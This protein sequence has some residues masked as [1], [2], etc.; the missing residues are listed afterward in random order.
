[1]EIVNQDQLLSGQREALIHVKRHRRFQP[2]REASF[3]K[4]GGYV[5]LPGC[6][7]RHKLAIDQVLERC[8]SGLVHLLVRELHV[9]ERFGQEKLDLILK[10]VDGFK[11]MEGGKRNCGGKGFFTEVCTMP[12]A[13][14]SKRM[15][16]MPVP[17]PWSVRQLLRLGRPEFMRSMA[18]AK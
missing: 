6:L 15:R 2:T 5:C 3:A 1:M 18:K 14:A 7:P 12:A 13:I 17:P 8:H 9:E 10:E 11:L 16:V 4:F